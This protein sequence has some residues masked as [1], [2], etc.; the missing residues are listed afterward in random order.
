MATT[1]TRFLKKHSGKGLSMNQLRLKYKREVGCG[2]IKKSTSCKKSK[3]CTWTK[4]KNGRKSS[5]GKKSTKKKRKSTKK[6]RKRMSAKK[7]RTSQRKRQAAKRMLTHCGPLRRDA[8]ATDEHCRWTKRRRG[9]STCGLKP[10]YGGI[11]DGS[12]S[13]LLSGTPF[14]SPV[15]RSSSPV[16]RSSS[17]RLSLAS[18]FSP[19]KVSSISCKDGICS[20]EV[21]GEVSGFGLW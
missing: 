10:R 19:P 20:R 16:S 17:P 5:C 9:L 7:R 21:S 4:R 18:L 14:N 11:R 15:S 13:D 3:S 8:C 12:I 6:K 2:S 1:W